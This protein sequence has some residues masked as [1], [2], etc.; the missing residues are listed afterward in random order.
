V[1]S[2]IVHHL[3]V[4]YVCNQFVQ[5]QREFGLCIFP[6]VV[7]KFDKWQHVRA[8]S[9]H[10]DAV[11]LVQYES[12]VEI[13]LQATIVRDVARLFAQTRD[14]FHARKMSDDGDILH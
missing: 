11:N 9:E 7:A 2:Y 4:K 6:S 3:A 1:L 8:L 5:R 14:E 12:M 10:D 13:E